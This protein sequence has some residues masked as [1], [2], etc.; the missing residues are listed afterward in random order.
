VDAKAVGISLFGPYVLAVEL[1]SMLLLGS[2]W[3]RPIHLGR[4]P[5]RAGEAEQGATAMMDEAASI[6]LE[7]GL[8]LAGD[9]LFCTGPG[10]PDGY[11]RNLLFVL[12]SLEVMMN[13]CALAFVV[14]G[15]RWGQPMARSCSF[16]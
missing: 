3:S 13:A 12:M 15:S 7:H 16:W 9:L 6:P 4:G 5:E 11:R 10:R 2:V 14:A 8:A 1:A